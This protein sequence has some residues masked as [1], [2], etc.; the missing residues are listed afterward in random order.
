LADASEVRRLNLMAKVAYSCK[1][2]G[3]AQAVG[4]FDDFGIAL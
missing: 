1:Q 4:G 2:H 3:Q